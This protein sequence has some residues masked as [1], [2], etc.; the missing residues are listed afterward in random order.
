MN[1]KAHAALR[2]PSPVLWVALIGALSVGTTSAYA[3][4]A[5]FAA[6]SALAAIGFGRREGLVAVLVGWLANQVVGFGFLGYPINGMAFVWCGLIGAAMIAG[7]LA[8]R[9]SIDALSSFLSV[10]TASALALAMA[11]VVFSALMYGSALVLGGAAGFTVEGMAWVL[12][13]DVVAY[14]GMLMLHVLLKAIVER[15]SPLAVPAA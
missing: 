8:A 10:A 5:P 7:Y 1:Q 3:C 11:F 9:F 6:M 13:V 15:T 4:G 12:A 2:T 14:A